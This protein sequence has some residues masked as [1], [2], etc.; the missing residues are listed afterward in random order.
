[1]TNGNVTLGRIRE[2]WI[3]EEEG[4]KKW[5]EIMCYWFAKIGE[6][7][8]IK[9]LCN[10]FPI[11]Y[12]KRE[13]ISERELMEKFIW[14]VTSLLYTPQLENIRSKQKNKKTVNSMRK[15]F[16]CNTMLF[17]RQ[18]RER[19][20]K[21][22]DMRGSIDALT[23][24]IRFFTPKC[25]TNKKKKSKARTTRRRGSPICI[26]RSINTG[27]DFFVLSNFFFIPLPPYL[28]NVTGRQVLDIDIRMKN[29]IR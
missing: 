11:G 12:M 27:K 10:L 28:T 5:N 8:K 2:D 29:Y 18:E 15:W 16:A 17:M 20:Q 23:T 25:R 14:N 19:E 26:F 7:R 24:H 4:R 21:K 3:V 22:V 6:E 13:T 1:M 9:F